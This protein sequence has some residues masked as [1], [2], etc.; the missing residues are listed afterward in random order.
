[1]PLHAWVLGN[2]F[3]LSKK[4][5]KMHEND[6]SGSRAQ[7]KP[8]SKIEARNRVDF[9]SHQATTKLLTGAGL[10]RLYNRFAFSLTKQ[11]SK[12]ESRVSDD[13]TYIPDFFGFVQGYLTPALM[14]A[15]C[16]P[17]LLSLAPTFCE[18]LWDFVEH[19][20]PLF[21]GTPRLLCRGSHQR[22][23]RVLHH[24]RQ[25]HAYARQHFDPSALS[26]DADFDPC[27]G[28]SFFRKR[29]EVFLQMDNFDY[30][31]VASEDL[32]LIFG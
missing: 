9:H 5:A 17:Q 19:A 10:Y 18:D 12:A 15:L 8:L 4:A 29:Q 21:L 11:I 1:M 27:W 25:W 16:G 7:P 28:S 2:V 22:R 30:A 14:E 32:G 20:S 23:D 3:G 13:W 24:L 31:A 6:N 26:E